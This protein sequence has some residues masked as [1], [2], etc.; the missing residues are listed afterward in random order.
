MNRYALTI[1]NW[2]QE[3]LI[4]VL[5]LPT[6]Y[7]V[8]GFEKTT[9]N[10]LQIYM[11]TD[12]NFKYLKALLP[13]AHIERARKSKEVNVKYCKKGGQFIESAAPSLAGGCSV[14]EDTQL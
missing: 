8:I 5:A 14:T 10:H 11:E 1:N 9:V 2:N 4:A 6:A 7:Y 3:E 13:R 12:K